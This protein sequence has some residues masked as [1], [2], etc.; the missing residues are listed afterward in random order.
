MQSDPIEKSHHNSST[1]ADLFIVEETGEGEEEAEE[2]ELDIEALLSTV[3]EDADPLELVLV[4]VVEYCA[5]FSSIAK[6][7]LI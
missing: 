6:H 4:E 5:S 1:K 7:C 3:V 2:A